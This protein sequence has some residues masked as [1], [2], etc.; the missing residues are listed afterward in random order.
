MK[1]FKETLLFIAVFFVLGSSI[2]AHAIEQKRD[3]KPLVVSKEVAADEINFWARQMS[4]H[5]LFLYLGIVDEQLKAQGLQLHQ[6]FEQY[7]KLIGQQPTIE[8]YSKIIPLLHKL[9]IYKLTVYNTLNTGK[10][11]GWIYPAFAEHV[12]LE[13]DYFLDKLTGRQFSPADEIAFWNKE[14]S[15]EAGLTA[16]LLDPSEHAR[17]K[18]AMELSMKIKCPPKSEADML[19]GI[20]LKNYKE[21]DAFNKQAKTAMANNAIKSIIHPVL[22]DHVTREGARAIEIFSRLQQ[23]K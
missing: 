14:R 16:H 7:R 3:C 20:S 1:H 9:R 17:V 10:W 19:I 6:E 22:L 8:N 21:L 15:G 23:N 4:E 2:S 13:L 18:Q 11:I 5:A 12:L